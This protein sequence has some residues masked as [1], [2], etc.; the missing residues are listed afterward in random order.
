[1]RF[2]NEMER[3]AIAIPTSS[4]R[5]LQGTPE[6]FPL[7]VFGRSTRESNCEC[8]RS[9]DATLLQTVFLQ[10]DNVVY[11]LMNRRNTGWLQQLAKIYDLPFEMQARNQPK[12]PPNYE[13]YLGRIEARLK[14]LKGDP[15]SKAL[16]EA[17]LESR[18][19]LISKYGLPESRR[20]SAEAAGLSVEQKQEIVEQAYLRTLTRYPNETEMGRSLEFIDQADD[21]I[22]GVRGLLW[23]LLNTK[24]F[25]LNH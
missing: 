10:N 15:A 19:R 1:M 2:Q 12:P 7:M 17:A 22:N 4:E 5:F 25:V 11:D 20:E 8:D 21:K 6:A 13:E 3:R 24:E 14:R 23:A 18:R 16:Y 9:T